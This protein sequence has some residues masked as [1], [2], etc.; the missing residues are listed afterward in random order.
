MTVIVTQTR[1]CAD[2]GRSLQM[3]F[4]RLLPFALAA[5][6]CGCASDLVI[7]AGDGDAIHLVGK[8]DN[9]DCDDPAYADV[10][11]VE[12][13]SLVFADGTRKTICSRKQD[14]RSRKQTVPELVNSCPPPLTVPSRTNMTVLQGPPILSENA[15][16]ALLHAIGVYQAR[17]D[18]ITVNVTDNR[19]PLILAL[20][21]YRK[22][23]WKIKLAQGVRV[24]GVILS[25]Y[26]TQ[27]LTGIPANIPIQT[28]TYEPSPCERCRP[29]NGFFYSYTTPHEK[30]REITGLDITLF[31]GQYEGEEF[32]ISA[33]Y[34]VQSGSAPLVKPPQE[35]KAGCRPIR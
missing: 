11:K 9:F 34:T 2:P 5:M 10:E 21:A 25:G 31:Q 17:N 6:L 19:R 33:G 7:D 16:T 28:Y 18:E 26:H 1:T 22:T 20:S 23:L 14:N 30:L 13:F 24:D 12:T 27:R 35:S 29:G 32:L 15:N 4:V 3:H 8:A